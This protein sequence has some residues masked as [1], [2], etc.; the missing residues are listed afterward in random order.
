M[1][2]I[3]SNL[4]E[5]RPAT[6]ISCYVNFA[7]HLQN[8]WNVNL[9][10]PGARNE[11]SLDDWRRF[12]IMIESFGYTCFEYWIVPTLFDRPS[13]MRSGCRPNI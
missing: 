7:E 3:N 6:H 11:W 5:T 9:L 13:P 1:P 2:S 10:Y 12:L 8:H 4:P